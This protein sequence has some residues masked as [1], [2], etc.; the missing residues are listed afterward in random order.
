VLSE[1]EPEVDV[2]ELVARSAE[3]VEVL[4]TEGLDEAQRRFN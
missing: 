2:D 3:A 4:A 1:F